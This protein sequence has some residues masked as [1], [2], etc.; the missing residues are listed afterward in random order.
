MRKVLGGVRDG[1]GAILKKSLKSIRKTIVY[2]DN[3]F[4]II[5]HI[6]NHLDSLTNYEILDYYGLNSPKELEKH[7]E[8]IKNILLKDEISKDEIKDVDSCFCMD[9]Y[10]EFKYLYKTKKEAEKQIDYS[11]QYKRVKLKIYPCPYHC[12]W[13]ISKV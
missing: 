8:K 7:V 9:R 11:Y 3:I 13:H 6:Y 12:G 1:R 4:K 5:K 10:K 2:N